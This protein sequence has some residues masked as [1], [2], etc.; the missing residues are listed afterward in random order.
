V[1]RERY[2][3]RL[4]KETGFSVES[5]NAQADSGENR[6]VNYRYN[7]IKS[8]AREPAGENKAE[9][10][11]IFT[12]MNQPQLAAAAGKELSEDDFSD[13]TYKKI[14]YLI[15]D[16]L[17]KG[18]S[19]GCAEILSLLTEPEEIRKANELLQGDFDEKNAEKVA[20]DCVQK[21]KVLSLEKKRQSLVARMAGAGEQDKKQLLKEL[22][23]IDKNL[24][25]KRSKPL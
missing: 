9:S 14:F 18:I 6:F 21:M 1:Q 24:Y 22:S 8:T 15:F 12:V 4:N 23:V 11:L 3:A 17:K 5:L 7:S 19:P 2:I 25:E 10:T 13:D 16:K 20:T